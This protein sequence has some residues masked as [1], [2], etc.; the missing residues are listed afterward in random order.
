MKL[1]KKLA[2]GSVVAIS[3]ISLTAC[4][5]NSNSNESK[6]SNKQLT[7]WVDTARVSWYKGV[8]KDFEKEHPNIKVKVTQNPNGSANA[9][10]DVAKD[11]SK[12]ADVFGV[13]NDQL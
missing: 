12:A 2:L 8:V 6:S 13:P 4:S 9:K 3:A 10:T 5:N 7:L 11:P 1:W